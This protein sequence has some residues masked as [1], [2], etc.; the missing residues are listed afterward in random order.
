[1]FEFMKDLSVVPP[2]MEGPYYNEKEPDKE[3]IAE[4]ERYVQATKNAEMARQLDSKLSETLDNWSTQN[5]AHAVWLYSEGRIGYY[6]CIFDS[7]T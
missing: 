6:S 2:L 7:F 4:R 1:M 5:L 3:M